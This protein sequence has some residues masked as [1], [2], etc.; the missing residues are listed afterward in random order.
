[1]LNIRIRNW[2]APW[3][4]GSGTDACPEHKVTSLYFS[5]KVTNPERLYGVKIMKIW[6]IENLTLGH[7]EESKEQT[8]KVRYTQFFSLPLAG[9]RETDE[10]ISWSATVVLV[11]WSPWV[12]WSPLVPVSWFPRVVVV[13]WSAGACVVEIIWWN[14]FSKASRDWS[15]GLHNSPGRQ[16]FLQVKKEKR[17]TNHCPI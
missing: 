5:P 17:K 16:D 7:L 3:A 14:S 8:V 6:A 2:C 10:L 15:S 9:W 4:Y 13:S 12:S 1:M 11:S